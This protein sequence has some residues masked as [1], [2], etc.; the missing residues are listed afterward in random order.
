MKRITGAFVL[1]CIMIRASGASAA[2]AA[3]PSDWQPVDQDV[4]A[5][6][7]AEPQAHL[8]SAK[9]DLAGNEP[10]EAAAEIRLAG[11]FLRIQEMRLAASSQGL[12]RLAKEIEAGVVVS[13]AQVDATFGSA[14]S[15]LDHR[16]GMIP[17]MTGAE[18]IYEDEAS[19]H[20]AQAKIHLARKQE[21][22]AAGDI[23]KAAAYLK[24]KALRAG[25][26]TQAGLLASATELER[27]ADTLDAGAASDAQDVEA[28]FARAKK[29][30]RSAL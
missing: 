23:R 15:A 28:A 14:M 26:E 24:L 4:W 22:L 18:T 1:G 10:K 9:E 25:Q 11:N 12:N 27:L 6:L 29:A 30:V 13:S 3:N 5:I 2:A 17:V 7:M 20:L 19:Y 16:Q 8:L 21:K